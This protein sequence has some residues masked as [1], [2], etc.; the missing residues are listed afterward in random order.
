MT[1]Y[2]Q[3]MTRDNELGGGAATAAVAA[4]IAIL[5]AGSTALTPLSVSYKQAFGFSEI[6]LTLVYA[7]YVVGNLAALLF[8]GR[9][10]DQIGRR[11]VSFAAFGAAALSTVIFLA[12]E[13]TTPLFVGRALSGLA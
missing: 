4:M 2:A 11:P 3:T 13:S 7:V 5:F 8:L 6:T 1:N 10:S 12:T 9:L